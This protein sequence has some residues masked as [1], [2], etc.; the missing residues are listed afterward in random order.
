MEKIQWIYWN[1]HLG[2][3]RNNIFGRY[4]KRK[5]EKE[6]VMWN[7]M[8]NTIASVV[9]REIPRQFYHE[10]FASIGV[11]T[12]RKLVERADQN[13]AE[14][15]HYDYQNIACYYKELTSKDTSH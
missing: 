7:K 13:K 10:M 1:T 5:Q 6:Y 2:G 9:M 3:Y 4:M 11:E 8:G 15:G 14:K 12:M